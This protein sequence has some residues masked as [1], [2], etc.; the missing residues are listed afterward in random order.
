MAASTKMTQEERES[1]LAGLHVGI[2]SIENP[3]RAP[4]SAPIWYDYTA[5]KGVWILTSPTSKKGVALEKA[6]R[7]SLVAQQE[8]LPYKY[9]TVEGPVV[10]VRAADLE[11][12]TR[13]MARRYLGE[14]M[15]DAYVESNLTGASNFYRMQ[16][17]T[18]LTV[19]YAK[20]N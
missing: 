20:A 8:D 14:E 19:D 6:G 15:G 17:E 9:V 13:P 11:D 10:E 5:E 18:W 7:F 16:P 2:I 3:G 4:L 1:F 12:D